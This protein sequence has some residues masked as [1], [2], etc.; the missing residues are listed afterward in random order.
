LSEPAACR[1]EV[2]FR[3][4]GSNVM[5]MPR[6]CEYEYAQQPEPGGD[7]VLT[8]LA[9]EL[10]SLIVTFAWLSGMSMQNVA[11]PPGGIVKT[12]HRALPLSMLCALYKALDS[13]CDARGS[14]GTEELQ[15]CEVEVGSD[16]DEDV[17][18][19]LLEVVTASVPKTTR[20]HAMTAANT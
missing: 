2:R 3:E 9:S 13:D 6:A 12:S 11:V 17:D 18:G 20:R 7:V 1:K 16:D 8:I 19:A 5:L 14:S 4:D 15:D 10:R